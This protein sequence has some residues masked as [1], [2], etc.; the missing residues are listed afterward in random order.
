MENNKNQKKKFN[1]EKY[2]IQSKERIK[3]DKIRKIKMLINLLNV[4]NELNKGSND[5]RIIIIEYLQKMNTDNNRVDTINI[6][7]LLNL[8]I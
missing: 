3:N 8:L 6:D 4:D 5:I 1:S 7:F 2:K